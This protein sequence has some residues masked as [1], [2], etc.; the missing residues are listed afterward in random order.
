M[1]FYR[2]SQAPTCLEWDE[3]VQIQLVAADC[4]DFIFPIRV[5]SMPVDIPKSALFPFLARYFGA[6]LPADV[7]PD[8]VALKSAILEMD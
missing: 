2:W 3:H 4:C 8:Q 7:H 1:M 6:N 5:G